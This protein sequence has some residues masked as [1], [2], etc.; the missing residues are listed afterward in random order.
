MANNPYSNFKVVLRTDGTLD[1]S[2]AKGIAF[3][4]NIKDDNGT[5]T[6][7]LSIHSIGNPAGDFTTPTIAANLTLNTTHT[8]LITDDGLNVALYFDGSLTP[9]LSTNSTFS[10]GNKI[11]FYNR[12]GSAGGSSISA[13]GITE[14][15]YLAI[16]NTG[17]IIGLI[18]SVIEG[19]L[20]SKHPAMRWPIV[21]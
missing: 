12:E 2:E 15:D 5:T 13:N 9:T 6:D 19:V 7:N 14:I 3:Q 1:S 16:T 21:F 11:T 8:F 10:V 20:F 17:P 18:K 4:F